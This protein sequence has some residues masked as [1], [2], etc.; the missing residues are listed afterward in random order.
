VSDIDKLVCLEQTGNVTQPNPINVAFGRAVAKRRDELN[1]T[2][3][4]LA[5]LAGL[6]RA[7]IASI[8]K[9]RQNILL[10]QVYDLAQA[11]RLRQVGDLLPARP[12]PKANDVQVRVSGGSLSEGDEAHVLELIGRW[13]PADKAAPIHEG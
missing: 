1:M 9:G 6:S 11:L 13:M 10:H 4:K 3:E 2:Q 8:E 7:S 12:T 5:G